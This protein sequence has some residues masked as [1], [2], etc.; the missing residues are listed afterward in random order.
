MLYIVPIYSTMYTWSGDGPD[1]RQERE[2]S[3]VANRKSLALVD[4]LQEMVNELVDHLTD[5]LDDDPKP[6][7][8]DKLSEAMEIRKQITKLSLTIDK[9]Q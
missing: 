3:K 9:E 8:F 6:F 4:G 7:N 5:V 2:M 1:L